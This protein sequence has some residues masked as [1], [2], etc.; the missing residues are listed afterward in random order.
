M[1][2]GQGEPLADKEGDLG[3]EHNDL[4][5]QIGLVGSLQPENPHRPEEGEIKK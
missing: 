4:D 1:A 5:G 3:A 2:A